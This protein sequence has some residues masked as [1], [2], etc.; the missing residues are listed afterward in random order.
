MRALR[1]YYRSR[2]KYLCGLVVLVVR[3]AWQDKCSIKNTHTELWH[4][5]PMALWL[6]HTRSHAQ[7]A[8]RYMLHPRT[9]THTRTRTHSHTRARARAHP[10]P[11]LICVRCP[12][13][14]RPQVFFASRSSALLGR[15][16]SSSTGWP[17]AVGASLRPCSC[18]V[19]HDVMT[20]QQLGPCLVSSKPT[21]CR[22]TTYT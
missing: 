9:H 16:A 7:D 10:E 20:S 21:P 17:T 18:C 15:A 14:P 11:D 13:K 6:T 3:F 12:L 1:I 8:A 19:N 4:Y 2:L 22:K 5:R